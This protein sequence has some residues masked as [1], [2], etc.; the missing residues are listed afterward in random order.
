MKSP[1]E[2]AHFVRQAD[3][4]ECTCYK[5][6]AIWLNSRAVVTGGCV[7]GFFCGKCEWMNAR[8]SGAHE[9]ADLGEN[10][11]GRDPPGPPLKIRTYDRPGGKKE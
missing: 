8:G 10:I 4:G 9:R 1:P 7:D 6:H 5:K 3:H 11:E 2:P